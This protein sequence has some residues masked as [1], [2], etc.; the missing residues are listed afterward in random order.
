[1][2]LLQL[3]LLLLL[4]AST[5]ASL[6]RLQGAAQPARSLTLQSML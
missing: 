1:M 5:A 4:Q 6:L 3:L 2:L